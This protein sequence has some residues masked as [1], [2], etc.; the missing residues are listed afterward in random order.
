M[1]KNPEFR[2]RCQPQNPSPTGTGAS[3]SQRRNP[4]SARGDFLGRAFGK[5][6]AGPAG[7]WHGAPVPAGLRLTPFVSRR[8]SVLCR[9]RPPKGPAPPAAGWPPA[10]GTC[11]HFYPLT[12]VQEETPM[13]SNEP[14]PLSVLPQ[15]SHTQGT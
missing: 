2:N 10:P 15:A 8:H 5:A 11:C 14:A 9:L 12:T 3:G 6:G 1:R 13:E 4:A 7:G